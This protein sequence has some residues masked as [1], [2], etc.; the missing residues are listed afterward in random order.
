[1]EQKTKNPDGIMDNSLRRILLLMLRNWYFYLIALV[2]FAG[3]A[4]VFLKYNLP[5]YS[6]E[7]YILVEEENN[8][9]G[10]DLLEGF[11]MRP[12]VQNLD[13]QI[14]ILQS[15]TIIKEAIENLGFETDVYR[16]GLFSKASYYPL[17]PIK[18]EPGSLGLPYDIEFVFQYVGDE[19]FSIRNSFKSR[20]KIELD[21]IGT[22]GKEL[23]IAD[24]SF[25]IF[26]VLEMESVYMD[27][28]KFYLQFHSMDKLVQEYAESVV[29]ENAT[30]DG[31]IV[32][33]SHES[34]NMIKGLLFLEKL[35]EVFIRGNLEKKNI[36]AERIIDFIE[37]QLTDVRDSLE[38]TETELQEFRS[39]NRIMDVSAQTEQIITQALVLENEKASLNLEKNYYHYLDDYLTDET[40][41]NNPI[42]PASMGIADPNL[43]VLIQEFSS[44][45]ADFFST[46]VGE[47]NPMQGQ[48]EM[49]IQNVKRSI[50]ETLS[51]I[52]QANQ[53]AIAENERQM[54]RL[55]SE[56][57]KLP[58]KEQQ[59]LGFER[60]FNLN[61]EMY[62]F[63]LQ[64]RAEAQ[65]QKA[66]NTPDHEL[67]DPA[68]SM[69]IVAPVPL[70]VL[71]LA[72]SLAVVI[73]S[74]IL[75]F[76]NF[77][78]NTRISSE[79]DIQLISSL[80][81]LAQFPHSR[82]SYYNVVLTDS[83]SRISEAFRSFRTRMEFFT[84]ET[85]C[86]VIVVSSS[87]PGEGK[88]F[89]AVNMASVYSLL[90]VKTL[91]VGYDFRR[92]TL[93]KSFELPQE[94][95]IV[96]YLI[97]KKNLEEI[98]VHSGY[99]N[100]DILPSGS[101][102]PNPSEL[103]NSEKSKELFKL[104]KKNYDCIIVD[105]A[106]VGVVADIYPVASIADALMLVVRH[107]FT[108]KNALGTTL[109]DLNGHQINNLGLL[110][111]DVKISSNSYR[112]NYKYKYEYKPEKQRKKIREVFSFDWK[113]K[114]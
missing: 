105:S 2:L 95:G 6:A 71:A 13:N 76:I 88:T 92:P 100:L 26:P 27:G 84:K 57:T 111:N 41:K 114:S 32:Q 113:A 14:M 70:M 39:V 66:S 51:G 9:P 68:R 64:R 91:L 28:G 30:R 83:N 104:L 7:A 40:I 33:V 98:I 59:L 93:S 65:I 74:I 15:Y 54:N 85:K 10:E 23:F 46:G 21:T 12:G 109:A 77:V 22:F 1:M 50:K 16:K 108:Q 73:P 18:I 45:Q 44:L 86:P 102:P 69:G 55:N 19:Q 5:T 11:S 36:E 63:L 78:F 37:G 47:R 97:G 110:I 112:Y 87:I 60:R 42:A 35:T 17:S 49:R 34:T 61:N 106:P 24:G 96:D 79:E 20:S 25:T 101:I 89:V 29:V 53:M 99:E 82:L 72:L 94:F 67:V 80:P 107:G 81:I 103:S 48:L 58:M 38:I 4:F 56:A 75:L 43:T 62:N 52:M 90:G 8:T 3:G 31:S